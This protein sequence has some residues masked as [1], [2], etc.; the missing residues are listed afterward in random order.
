MFRVAWGCEGSQWHVYHPVFVVFM[1]LD[2][3][4]EALYAG[5]MLAQ[6]QA[7]L[8]HIR[9]VKACSFHCFHTFISNPFGHWLHLL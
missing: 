9:T 2:R 1:S 4:P 5:L 7:I 8:L 6:F 3:E